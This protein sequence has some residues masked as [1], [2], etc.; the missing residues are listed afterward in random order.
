M[1]QEFLEVANFATASEA[2]Q[3]R[4]VLKENGVD[5]FVDGGTVITALSHMSIG[6]GGVK[7]LVRAADV[8]R[9]REIIDSLQ[10]DSELTDAPWFCG[11]CQEEVDGGFQVCWSCGQARADVEQPFPPATS[12][13]HFASVRDSGSEAEDD[14]DDDSDYDYANPYMAPRNQSDL[15]SPAAPPPEINPDAEAMLVLAWRACIVGL[16]FLPVIAQ[17]YSMYLL[18]RASVIAAHFS[19]EGQKRF[20]RTLAFNVIGGGLYGLFFSGFFLR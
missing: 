5:A 18:I 6:L 9:A 7:V 14:A 1:P 11:A 8:P 20:N 15:D 17:L 19:P 2:E 10:E 12:Q 16:V 4:S 3:L 13:E